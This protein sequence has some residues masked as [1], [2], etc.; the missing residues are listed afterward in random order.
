MLVFAAMLAAIA[1]IDLLPIDLVPNETKILLFL[2]VLSPLLI[3][4]LIEVIWQLTKV[5]LWL[6]RWIR[7][8]VRRIGKLLRRRQ[9]N[10]QS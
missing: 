4:N 9:D 7:K 2:L 10:S 8:L 1:T 5:A 6:G 3:Y